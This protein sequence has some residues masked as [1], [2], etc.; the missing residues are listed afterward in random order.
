MTNNN[1][2]TTDP[3][4]IRV[5][6][7]QDIIE[8]RKN[9]H[10]DSSKLEIEEALDVVEDPIYITSDNKIKNGQTYYEYEEQRGIPPYK[11][12]T[13]AQLSETD[14]IAISWGR[15]TKPKDEDIIYFRKGGKLCPRNYTK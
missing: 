13:T 9:K 10:L 14:S 3:R 5:T 4:G 7:S 6:F 15:Q 2:Y 1:F 11:R 12:V 8:R